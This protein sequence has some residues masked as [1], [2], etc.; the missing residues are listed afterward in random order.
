MRPVKR[1][2]YILLVLIVFSISVSAQEATPE[3]TPDPYLFAFPLLPP[4]SAHL[5]EARACPLGDDITGDATPEADSACEFATTLLTVAEVRGQG[6]ASQDEIDDFEKLARMNPA[7]ILRLPIIASYYN[8]IELVAPPEIAAQPITTVH[9]RYTFSGLGN[10]LAYD[11]TITNADD[12]PDVSGDIQNDNNMGGSDSEATP[13]PIVLAETVDVDVVQA[14]GD[15]LSDLVPIGAQFSSAPCWDYY[16]DWT[17]TLTFADETTL[18]VVTNSSNLVGIGGPWQVQ[19]DGQDYM[20]YSNAF[21]AAIVDLLDALDLP[22]GETMAM[23]C[24]GVPDPLDS[25]WSD[26]A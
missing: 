15:G 10:S 9:L 7:I 3:P 14:L 2:I 25:A 23:G 5:E 4:D 11:V 26:G 20:Q 17:V 12:V 21:S 8:Q 16:P 18:D 13:E 6:D 1:P 19:I 24:G 22:L